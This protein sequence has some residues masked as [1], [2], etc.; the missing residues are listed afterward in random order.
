MLEVG[1][2]ESYEQLAQE[3]RLWINGTSTVFVRVLVNLQENPRY[4]CPNSYLSDADFERLKLPLATTPRMFQLPQ[5]Q[6]GP[7]SF[8]GPNWTGVISTAQVEVWKMDPLT[9]KACTD[10]RRMVRIY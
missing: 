8:K 10:G 9:G 5:N 6:Y 2:S 7:A 4:R 3:A 1:F